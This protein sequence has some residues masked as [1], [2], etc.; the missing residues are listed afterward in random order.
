MCPAIAIQAGCVDFPA[1]PVSGLGTWTLLSRLLFFKCT[2]ICE[3]VKPVGADAWVRSTARWTPRPITPKL[4][5]VYC[6]HTDEVLV[7]QCSFI[8]GLITMMAGGPCSGVS[9]G[10]NTDFTDEDAVVVQVVGISFHLILALAKG[11]D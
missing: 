9:L 5:V 6:I 10:K 7:A 3:T 8:P 4:A 1:P 11:W 2:D